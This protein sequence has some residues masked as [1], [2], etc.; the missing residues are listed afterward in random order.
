MTDREKKVFYHVGL[1]KTGTTF[2]QDLVFPKIENLY[3]LKRSWYKKAKKV[4]DRTDH[5]TFLV[6][7]EFD[8]QFEHEVGLFCKNFPNATPIVVFRRHDSY[9]AS[10]YRRFVKNGFCGPFTA[11]F[12]LEK[13]QGFFKKKELDYARHILYLENHFTQKPLVLIY[14]DLKNEPKAFIQRLV[15]AM[16]GTLDFSKVS[17][18]SHHTSYNEQQLKGIKAFGRMMNMTKR[19]VFKNGLL[20]LLWR[21]YMASI[22]YSVL[23]I[24]KWL[25]AS[26]FNSAPL[27]PPEQLEAVKTFYQKD[28]E[29]VVAYARGEQTSVQSILK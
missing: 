2:L 8:Q 26:W 11:F 27:M 9:I 12:D 23:Y 19:R 20:H 3:Y 13:D 17:L 15:D 18:R 29:Q 24:S 10:Q 28:W 5:H 7:L 1:G 25:P 22:R 21:L 16:G 4:V 6:S 14:D